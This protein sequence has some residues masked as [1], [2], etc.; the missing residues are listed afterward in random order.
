MRQNLVTARRRQNLPVGDIKPDLRSST[1]GLNS[2]QTEAQ[3]VD[4][5]PRRA[6]AP[7]RR[8][9]EPRV[10]APAPAPDHPGRGLS[11]PRQIDGWRLPV[12]IGLVPVR[13]PLPD[14]AVHVVQAEGVRLLL[15]DRMRLA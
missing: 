2:G 4:P 1:S 12:I 10:E 8:P 11:R 6:P 14:V 9:R 13:T 5:V 3:V 15:P 7:V